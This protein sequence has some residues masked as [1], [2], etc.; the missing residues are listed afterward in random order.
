MLFRSAINDNCIAVWTKNTW[1]KVGNLIQ[2]QGKINDYIV[3]PTQVL[4]LIDT[5][6]IEL[7]QKE[8]WALN[9]K[10]E[11]AKLQIFA[12]K[13]WK[14]ALFFLAQSQGEP[15]SNKWLYAWNLDNL[16]LNP[17]R[18]SFEDFTGT[19]LWMGKEHIFLLRHPYQMMV[20]ST[21]SPIEL[22][23][24]LSGPISPMSNFTEDETYCYIVRELGDIEV[25]RK[26]NW[27]QERLL[28]M[29]DYRL[30]SA[31][32][33]DDYE[34]LAARPSVGKETYLFAVSVKSWQAA[35]RTKILDVQDIIVTKD[36]IHVFVTPRA[37]TDA[38]GENRTD[39]GNMGIGGNTSGSGNA[40]IGAIISG[41]GNSSVGGN[42]GDPKDPK[43]NCIIYTKLG[44][45][46]KGMQVMPEPPSQSPYL[47]NLVGGT[48]AEPDFIQR[49]KHYPI[50]DDQW[51]LKLVELEYHPYLHQVKELHNETI[52]QLDTN[53]LD[54]Q[55]FQKTLKYRPI[56]FIKYTPSGFQ[57][58][59][60]TELSIREASKAEEL[61]VSTV[62]GYTPPN[63]I[64]GGPLQSG[65]NLIINT[66][67][68][69][70]EKIAKGGMALIYRAKDT[71][72]GHIRIVKQF[73]YTR[74]RDPETGIN[75]CEEYWTR[76]RVITSL[77]ATSPIR[78]MNCYGALKLDDLETPQYYL[79]LEYIPGDTLKEWY[80]SHKITID[81]LNKEGV[82]YLIENLVFP[83]LKHMQYVH[84]L[85][86]LHR[87]ITVNNILVVE[88]EKAVLPII[89]DWGIA[90]QM[91]LD[92]IA[93]PPQDYFSEIG[94]A[95]V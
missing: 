44:L 29:R 24:I 81:H 79:I 53:A 35:F 33:D 10:L 84:K 18:K 3:T 17:K 95:H 4:V 88:K 80:E 61:S 69:I 54:D 11:N 19:K 6:R 72:T 59:R 12:L 28:P 89:I 45:K 65:E 39:R 93:N 22:K 90:K 14:N 31:G 63:K 50:V 37:S 94:R 34:Y 5:K 46:Y 32:A 36:E 64:M 92:Q 21:F 82:I 26:K 1:V 60:E 41:G 48:S 68:E 47:L 74:Y 40:N 58:D 86:I 73:L 2:V 83:L 67:Y 55:E 62:I 77:Q 8:S 20:F 43:K 66:S 51:N 57:I 25:W 49:T 27:M 70:V 91:P 23:A 13:V 30:I 38:Q 78:A 85:G 76:E 87:D 42:T 16:A 56:Q 75:R 71:D 9:Q 15:P 52:I 7:Y